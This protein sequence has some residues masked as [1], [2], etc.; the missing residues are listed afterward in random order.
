MFSE[1]AAGQ[2]AAQ[3]AGNMVSYHGQPT[4]E[5]KDG[6]EPVLLHEGTK[7]VPASATD[8]TKVAAAN[9]R[10]QL[11]KLS[12]DPD[13]RKAAALVRET[14]VKNALSLSDAKADAIIEDIKKARQADPD[15]HVII[16]SS[17]LEPL[18]R[19]RK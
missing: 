18:R 1:E 13:V 15:H 8:K 10:Y 5:G 6:K 12:D 4:R 7:V 16:H 3:L 11:D 19:M 14:S 17:T 9:R 2:L